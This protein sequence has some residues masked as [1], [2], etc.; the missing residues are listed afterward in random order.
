MFTVAQGVDATIGR[1]PEG[2]MRTPWLLV[3]F[4]VGAVAIG[5]FDSGIGCP[6]GGCQPAQATVGAPAYSQTAAVPASR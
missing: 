1:L 5:L 3:I 2:C 6:A 4:L